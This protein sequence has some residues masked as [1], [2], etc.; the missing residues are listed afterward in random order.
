MDIIKR[1]MKMVFQ[2]EGWDYN[3]NGNVIKSR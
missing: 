2:T 3:E 1:M